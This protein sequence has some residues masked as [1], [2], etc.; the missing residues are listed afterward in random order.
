MSARRLATPNASE[1]DSDRSADRGPDPLR[2][3]VSLLLGALVF[4]ALAFSLHFMVVR[5]TPERWW[6][7]GAGERRSETP[8]MLALATLVTLPA[9]FTAGLMTARMAGRP[10]RLHGHGLSVV[11]AMVL[12]APLLVHP[13]HDAY[14]WGAFVV[15]LGLALA[16]VALGARVAQRMESSEQPVQQ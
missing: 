3:V 8:A 9:A 10:H 16:G 2:S 6:F 14:G 12:V 5:L 11:I 1:R 15:R 7:V 4:F 13:P